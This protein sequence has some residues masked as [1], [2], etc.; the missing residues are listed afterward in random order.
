MK[1]TAFTITGWLISIALLA[2]LAAKIDFG[3]LWT[4]LC[5][6]GWGWLVLA[7]IVNIIVIGL[8][9]IR[10]QWLMQ[11]QAKSPFWG[12]FK[13]TVIGMAGNNVLPARGGDWYKIYLLGKWENVSK[14]TLASVAGLDKLFD[15]LSIVILFGFLSLHSRFPVWVQKGTTIVSI[16]IL[17]SLALCIILLVHHRRNFQNE[18]EPGWLGHLAIKFGA[19]MSAL[20]NTKIVIATLINSIVICLLQV[21]TIWCCQM[22]FG[23]HLDIWIPALVFVAINLAITIPSAPSGV[24]PFEAAGVLAYTWFRIGTEAAFNIALMY[25][26]VQFFPITIAGFVFYFRTRDLKRSQVSN[27][28]AL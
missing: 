20:A 17:V 12:I 16:V 5:K 6:A 23:E 3:T 22:A 9:A 15:G 10:W 13:A 7:A 11:P 27:L 8:K 4:G 24:G 26:A 1:K 28:E 14:T 25:H 19:G 21:L 2:A 18:D